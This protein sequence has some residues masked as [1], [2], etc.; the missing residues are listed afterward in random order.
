MSHRFTALPAVRS[1]VL[2]SSAGAALA[3]VGVS[4]VRAD[5]VGRVKFHVL[6]AATQKPV[7]GAKIT[8][9][10]SA[11]VNPNLVLTTDANGEVTT[12]PLENRVW[13]ATTDADSFQVDARRVTVQADVTSEVTIR[14][15]AIAQG[16]GTVIVTRPLVRTGQTSSSTVR[17]QSFYQKFPLAAGNPQ[18]L[19][20]ALRSNPGFVEDSVNQAH[21]RGEHASTS[22]YINGFLLPGA[23]QGRAG[24]FLSPETIQTFDVQTG[25]YAPEYGGETAAILNLSLRSGTIDPFIDARL[26]GGGFGTFTGS[27]TFGGQAGA[28]AGG[29]DVHGDIAKK[30]G[31]L[32]NLSQYNTDNALEA[33]QPGNQSA[34]NAQQSTTAFGNFSYAAGPSDQFNLVINTAPARTEVANRTG[35]PDEYA[36]FGQGFG[37]AGALSAEEAQTRGIA[38]QEALRQD[39]YQRDNNTF[40]AFQYRKQFS[41]SLTGLFSLGY[42]NSKLDILNDNPEAFRNA[43]V[44]SATLAEDSSLEF[45]PTIK[46]EY[47]QT[48]F[49]AS[50]T[51]VR[52]RHTFKFGGLYSDQSGD[53]SY[54]LIPGSQAALNALFATDPRLAPQG[55]TLDEDGNY[56]LGTATATPT[57]QV[58]R[59][60]YYA[61]G[62][63]QDTYRVTRRFTLNYGLR[64]DAY[65]QSQN[66]GQDSVNQTRLSP[67]INTAYV[68]APLTVARLSYNRLFTQPPLAQG[69]I[70]GLSVQPQMTDLYEANVEKQFGGNQT[71]KVAYY[72]KED[73]NQLDTGILIEGTQ[74]GAYT[75]IS[76][77]KATIK[78]FE[79]SYDLNPRNSIGWG[80]Y[81][82]WAN[83]T[84]KPRGLNNLGEVIDDAY[85]DHD[86]LN[87]ITGG[88]SYGLPSGA[89]AGLSYYYGSGTASS[90]LDET[91]GRQGRQEVNLRVGTGEQQRKKQAVG[92]TLEVQNLFDSRKR[93]NF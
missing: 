30:F 79:F 82:A 93:V 37:Y 39:I 32:V 48:E 86:Q 84:A 65:K 91:S 8:L 55:G 59:E 87:T 60:G 31:Y 92:F 90:V 28:A 83:S 40:T 47:D 2:F 42:S 85:N 46:R 25:A 36:P 63:V 16:S 14:L 54:Q 70:L 20:K 61:A 24:Q 13:V 72:Q 71:V 74:I 41:P 43:T 80:G 9:E 69:A 68:I 27:L 17:D 1:F 81:L 44:S 15:G 50:L 77:G 52:S 19:T 49:S 56:L 78:G 26:G 23:L 76:L 75:S 38:S 58:K 18:S 51:A 33:P 7:P 6:S 64:L 73:R 5:V 12:P 45:S 10:D 35:L 88:V 53:E 67:R 4:P 57:L 62:Y 3:S 21:P 34:H 66:L 29:A 11:N 22:V 89:E